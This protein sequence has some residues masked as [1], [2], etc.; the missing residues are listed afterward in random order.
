[1]GEKKKEKRKEK[2]T[3]VLVALKSCRTKYGWNCN[4]RKMQK[5]MED[6]AHKILRQRGGGS[7]YTPRPKR[8]STFQLTVTLSQAGK[9]EK[10]KTK[11]SMTGVNYSFP[12]KRREGD[13]TTRR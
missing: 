5:H 9:T 8:R 1:M 12:D 11:K 13:S 7:T 2:K 4:A 6:G 3:R 10:K